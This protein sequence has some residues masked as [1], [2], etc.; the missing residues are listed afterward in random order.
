MATINETALRNYALRSVKTFK[1]FDGGGFNAIIT[2]DGGKKIADVLDEGNGGALR[3][4]V[5]DRDAMS[6][7]ARALGVENGARICDGPVDT[8]VCQQVDAFEADKWLRRQ[9]K[10]KT[11]FRLPGDKEGDY[12]QILAPRSPK[13]DAF[14]MKKYPTAVIVEV[15]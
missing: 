11:L 5:K 2:Y 15:K 14:I 12:R 10:T 3:Y 4:D 1:T 7:L 9:L 6:G 8:W 13:V